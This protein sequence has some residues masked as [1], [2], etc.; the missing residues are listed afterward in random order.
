MFITFEGGEGSGKTTQVAILARHLAG[1][2][3]EVVQTREPGGTAMGEAIRAVLFDERHGHMDARTELFLYLASRAQQVEEKIRPALAA[4]KIV[5]CDRFTD[6]T[7][8]YQGYGRRLSPDAILPL[9]DFAA[10][11]V[12]PDVTFLLDLDVSVGLA[13]LSSRGDINRF[14]RET[15]AFH[16]TIRQGYLTLA[17]QHPERIRVIRADADIDTVAEEIRAHTDPELPHQKS[18]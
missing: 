15:V 4:G 18:T 3:Y 14:D 9:L 11:G 8:V 5:L 16:E 12:I 1:R 2:G 6:A 13:R 17:R 7:W 10:A